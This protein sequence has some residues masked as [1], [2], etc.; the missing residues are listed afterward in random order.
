MHRRGID[1]PPPGEEQKEERESE[2]GYSE[3]CEGGGEK[4]NSGSL[5]KVLR[6]SRQ[7]CAEPSLGRISPN[8]Q[9]GTNVSTYTS[10]RSVKSGYYSRFRPFKGLLFV[11]QC[12]Y[13]HVTVRLCMGAPI[14]ICN[15]ISRGPHVYII[16]TGSRLSLFGRS[17][18]VVRRGE[19]R[20]SK[21]E[22]AQLCTYLLPKWQRDGMGGL[23]LSTDG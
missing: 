21:E 22:E 6:E 18:I 9:E 5:Y 11:E 10:T 20:R 13:K 19:T 16:Y 12:L 4:E 14:Q 7:T 1:S 3:T 8:S 15:C 17:M 2:S 23:L